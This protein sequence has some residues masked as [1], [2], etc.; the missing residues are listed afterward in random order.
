M[1][2]PDYSSKTQKISD[3]SDAAQRKIAFPAALIFDP[4]NG[5]VRLLHSGGGVIVM[6]NAAPVP[7]TIEEKFSRLVRRWRKET[8]HISS[9]HEKSMNLAYQKI[10]GMGKE[11]L[12]FIFRD[13]ERTHD[14]WIWALTAIIDDESIPDTQGLESFSEVVDAWLSWAKANDYLG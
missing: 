5:S 4:S 6:P 1:P 14:D 9:V 13:F 3:G 12:P 7:S 2:N 11:V 8:R 10:I